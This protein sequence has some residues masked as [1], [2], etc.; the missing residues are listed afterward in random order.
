MLLSIFAPVSCFL[1]S[2]EMFYIIGQTSI[3]HWV[4]LNLNRKIL[5]TQL[6]GMKTAKEYEVYI[7]CTWDHTRCIFLEAPS[8]NNWQKY[9]MEKHLAFC[10]T[11]SRTIIS[12]QIA[13]TC[14][15]QFDWKCVLIIGDFGRRM[16]KLNFASICSPNAGCLYR[17]V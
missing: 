11:L 13:H 12:A 8:R 6:N 7:L 5:W 15:R 4:I 9:K 1:S 14:Q 3:C 16:L 10:C 17:S 2:M